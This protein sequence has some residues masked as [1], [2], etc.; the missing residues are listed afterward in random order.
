M[1]WATVVN[2]QLVY[3]WRETTGGYWNTYV[4]IYKP[5]QPA[6]P[7]KVSDHNGYA[8][9]VMN[10]HGDFTCIAPLNNAT[11]VVVWSDGR[12]RDMDYGYGWIY[13]Q[14]IQ[15]TTQNT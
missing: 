5:G 1:P 11:A 6:T 2:H 15:L 4:A 7:V 13:S 3:D 8:S 14:V 9:D 12:G 10:W